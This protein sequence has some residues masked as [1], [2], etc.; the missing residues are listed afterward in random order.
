ML[1]A[2]IKGY[3]IS[4]TKGNQYPQRCKS[5]SV[6]MRSISRIH[7]RWKKD[8]PNVRP[9]QNKWTKALHPITGVCLF[10]SLS[11]YTYAQMHIH[12]V[13]MTGWQTVSHTSTVL[14]KI[15]LS[16]LSLPRRKSSFLWSLYSEGLREERRK[17]QTEWQTD[18]RRGGG[19][20]GEE[21]R[22]GG[23]RRDERR[24][25]ESRWEAV[26]RFVHSP[27]VPG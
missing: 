5:A 1:R 23:C 20:R 13:N 15:S 22:R 19:R 6:C 10:P 12:L 21:R 7:S 4:S 24:R 8:H 2:V 18:R 14:E 16:P 9:I 26:R 11:K 3:F 25:R 27:A 17:W